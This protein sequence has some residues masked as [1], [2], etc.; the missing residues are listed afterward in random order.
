MNTGP[1]ASFNLSENTVTYSLNNLSE[2][3]MIEMLS[4]L[5]EKEEVSDELNTLSNKIFL[6]LNRVS[7]P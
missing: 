6:I 3:L 7:L 2:E 1:T 4:I 5:M